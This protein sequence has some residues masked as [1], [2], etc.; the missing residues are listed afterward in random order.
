MM[1]CT[2]TAS[3]I[4]SHPLSSALPNT[5]PVNGAG[6]TVLSGSNSKVELE[7]SS[8]AEGGDGGVGGGGEGEGKGGRGAG[9]GAGRWGKGRRGARRR[10]LRGRPW[11]PPWRAGMGHGREK[12]FGGGG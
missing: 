5:P 11:G 8:G 10:G 4:P 2:W 9:R 12:G 3:T 6:G 7:A 1:G